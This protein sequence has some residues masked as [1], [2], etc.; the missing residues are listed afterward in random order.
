MKPNE[1]SPSAKRGIPK[2]AACLVAICVAVVAIPP[3]VVFLLYSIGKSCPV[4]AAPWTAG[5]MLGYCGAVDAAVVALLG[6]FFSIQD[7]WEQQRAQLRESTAPYF[8]MVILKAMNKKNPFS[9]YVSTEGDEA[10]AVCDDDSPSGYYEVDVR[11]V[12]AIVGDDIVYRSRLSDKQRERVESTLLT[13]E[14]AEGTFAIVSNPVISI[15]LRFRNVG[16]GCANGVRVGVNRKEDEWKGVCSWSLDHGEDFYLLI[17]IDTDHNVLGDYEVR[18]VFN[19]CLGYRYM[20]AFSLFV[21]R[22]ASGR[23][24]ASIDYVGRKTVID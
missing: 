19:D 15:P 9:P 23:A 6:L 13:E 20:E 16:E 8:S 14:I 24:N 1:F 17:Y 10:K 7:G 3:S 2:G 18:I 21:E 5:E 4:I 22:D 12:Y 11:E